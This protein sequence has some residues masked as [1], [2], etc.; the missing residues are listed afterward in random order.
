[1]MSNY[2]HKNDIYQIHISKSLNHFNRIK[3]KYNLKLYDKNNNNSLLVF[4]LYDP[5]DYRIVKNHKGCVYILWGGS[6]IDDRIK[7]SKYMINKIGKLAKNRIINHIAISN[8]IYNRLKKHSFEAIKMKLNL[9]DTNIFK[10]L[11]KLN[12]NSNTIYVYNGLTK[13]KEWIYG[14]ELYEEIMNR[15]PEFKYIFSNKINVPYES[16]P[17]IYSKCFIG[18]R[19]TKHDGN[20]NTVQEFE[21]MKIPIIH[22]GECKNSIGWNNID[23]IELQIRYRH[24][25]LFNQRISNRRKILFVCNDY[26]SYGG[27]ATNC[28]DLIKWYEKNGFRTYGIFIHQ[29][30]SK[31]IWN[32]KY[33]N[34]EIITNEKNIKSALKECYN[35]FNSD[36]ELIIFRSYTNYNY[37]KSYKCKKIFFV[38]G[39]FLNHLDKPYNQLSKLEIKKFINRRTI[40]LCKKVDTIYVASNHTKLLLKRYYNIDSHI[41]YFNYIPYYNRKIPKISHNRKYLYGIIQSDFNRKIKNIS[42]ELIKKLGKYKDKV[43]LIGLNSGMYS[44]YGFIC[45]NLMTHKDVKK[46]MQNIEYIIQPSFYESMSN[47]IIEARYSGCKIISNIEEIN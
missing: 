45:K 25:Y 34:I 17:Q 8:D 30:S 3:D 37:F 38:P 4:G 22:N 23:D 35:Y 10:P 28:F 12:I 39:L 43:I 36:P 29:D 6:D 33:K 41:L 13:N 46:Y 32:N 44:N 16:M 18:L 42:E 14:K 47:I 2:F 20:A 27:A 9:V 15:L 19:L 1:M 7:Y 11:D 5:I 31:I 26:P 21:A 24:I 40:S